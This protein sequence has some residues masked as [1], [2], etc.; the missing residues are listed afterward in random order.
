MRKSVLLKGLLEKK[1]NAYHEVF[2]TATGQGNLAEDFGNIISKLIE[3]NLEDRVTC[4]QLLQILRYHSRGI[5]RNAEA[6]KSFSI[7]YSFETNEMYS[8]QIISIEK[9]KEMI[10]KQYMRKVS[11]V[12][13]RKTFLKNTQL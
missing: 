13:K 2:I 11:A 4:T 6:L 3:E 5:F 7:A 10:I 9:Y 8:L 12:W 1:R